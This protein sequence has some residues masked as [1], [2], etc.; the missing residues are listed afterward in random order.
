MIFKKNLESFFYKNNFY[1]YQKQKYDSFVR[2]FETDSNI[3]T[4]SF[5]ILTLPSRYTWIQNFRIMWSAWRRDGSNRSN[6]CWCETAPLCLQYN[7]NKNYVIRRVNFFYSTNTTNLSKYTQSFN[8][9]SIESLNFRRADKLSR[10]MSQL[11]KVKALIKKYS[12][13]RADNRSSRWVICT[14]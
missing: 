5:F 3:S 1:S 2:Y 14:H 8:E 13:L 10:R 9:F 4:K 6:C 12:S 11:D 7:K